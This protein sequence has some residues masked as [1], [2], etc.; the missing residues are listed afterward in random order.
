MASICSFARSAENTVSGAVAGTSAGGRATRTTARSD[1]KIIPTTEARRIGIQAVRW[2]NGSP[3]RVPCAASFHD[4]FYIESG[5]GHHRDRYWVG[6]VIGVGM[7]GA[8]Q[9]GVGKRV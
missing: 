4:G 7:T 6:P 2:G 5:R 1:S 9:I 8:S 3:T